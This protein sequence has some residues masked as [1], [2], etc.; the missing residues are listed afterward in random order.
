[1][2]RTPSDHRA[3]N[4]LGQITASV[5]AATETRKDVRLSEVVEA[6]RNAKQ[7]YQR[8]RG[9][10]FDSSTPGPQ[11][12]QRTQHGQIA[13]K[14]TVADTNARDILGGKKPTATYDGLALGDATDLIVDGHPIQSKYGKSTYISLREIIRHLQE[15]GPDNPPFFQIPIEQ[16]AQLHELRDSDT[17]KGVNESDIEAI[18][19]QLGM[20]EEL[21]G[22]DPDGII[23]AG[24]ATWDEVQLGRIGDTIEDREQEVEIR[25]D[26]RREQ[27]VDHYAPS[28]AKLAETTV[29]GGVTGAGVAITQTFFLKCRQ[30]KNPFKGEFTRTDW[31]E[32]G[33]AGGKGNAAGMVSGSTLYMLTN[34]TDLVAPFAGSLVSMMMGIN[35]LR[36][37]F[38][39]GNIDRDQF[40]DLCHVTASEAALVGLA[41]AA[42]QAMLPIP[43]LG[44]FVGII[45]GKVVTA[46][47]KGRWE[48]DAIELVARLKDYEY[49]AMTHLD[50]ECRRLLASIEAHFVELDRLEELAFDPA[51]N[52]DLRLRTSA[53]LARRVSVSDKLIMDSTDEVDVFMTE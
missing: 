34:A 49:W 35:N 47:L 41:A 37:D 32:I 46:S 31:T 42:G 1:M 52:T 8:V 48:V 33:V 17:I 7:E 45:A 40:V 2:S 23:R 6:C 5:L 9:F 26:E 38:R 4:V 50:E 13:E 27:I 16:R 15:K 20:I 12:P 22:Q 51:T 10:V 53:M 44:A 36:R 25:S 24:T 21:S 30:G 29:V 11:G 28:V 3:P 18:R 43:F 14:L 19:R 39:T